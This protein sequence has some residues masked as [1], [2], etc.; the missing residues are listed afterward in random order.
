MSK[1]DARCAPDARHAQALAKEKGGGN[2]RRP[3]RNMHALRRVIYIFTNMFNSQPVLPV[4]RSGASVTA[5]Q[6]HSS[7]SSAIGW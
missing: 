5:R 4:K 2:V 1:A 6:T 7:P 3:S